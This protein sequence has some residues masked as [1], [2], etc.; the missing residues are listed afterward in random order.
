[1]S[2][3]LARPLLRAPRIKPAFHSIGP[4]TTRKHSKQTWRPRAS[5][6]RRPV[7]AS[8]AALA[9][10]AAVVVQLQDEDEEDNAASASMNPLSL[11]SVDHLASTTRHLASVPL[12]ELF[13]AWIVYR[14]SEIPLLVDWAPRIE[15]GLSAFRDSVPLLGPA[16]YSVYRFVVRH[17]FFPIFV[18][19]ESPEQAREVMSTLLRR[20]CGSLM[21]YSVEAEAGSHSIKGHHLHADIIDRTA[22]AIRIAGNFPTYTESSELK[23]TW[24]AISEFD[25]SPTEIAS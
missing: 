16:A 6:A 18:G 25:W 7:I 22:D 5:I 17:T 12:R 10:T 14:S 21:C 3:C 9:C 19:G 15:L 11:L 13:R 1:M 4:C 20:G 8:I 23:P 24:C 2:C